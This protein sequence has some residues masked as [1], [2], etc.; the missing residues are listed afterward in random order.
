MYAWRSFAANAYHACGED[1]A[2]AR[3][4]AEE[5]ELAGTWGV[6]STLGGTHLNAATTLSGP[7]RS[8]HLEAAVRLLATSPLKIRYAT[9]LLGLAEERRTAGRPEE[10]AALVAEGGTLAWRLGSRSLVS[11]AEALGWWPE[12]PGGDPPAVAVPVGDRR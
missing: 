11:R 5:L 8:R 9:A 6:P 10:L 3:L 7:G 2:A 4:V 12:R 1:Q